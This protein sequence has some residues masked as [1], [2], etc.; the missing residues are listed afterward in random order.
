[1]A[2]TPTK[3]AQKYSPP[4]TSRAKGGYLL[5]L[6]IS[7][8]ESLLLLIS[9]PDFMTKIRAILATY[10]TETALFFSSAGAVN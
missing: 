2:T 3:R 5:L 4:L 8:P 10:K 9:S 1:M 7:P 6:T